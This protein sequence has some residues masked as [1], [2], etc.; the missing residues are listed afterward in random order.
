MRVRLIGLVLLG[1]AVASCGG[2]PSGVFRSDRSSDLLTAPPLTQV[3]GGGLWVAPVTGADA[4]AEAFRKALARSL[5]ERDVPAG[6]D[7]PGPRSLVLAATAG[8][9]THAGGG[10]VDIAWRLT[11]PDGAVLDDFFGRAPLDFRVERPETQAALIAVAD[12]MARLLAPPQAAAPPPPTVVWTPPAET[13]GFA[14]GGPLAR[15]MATALVERGFRPATGVSGAGAVVRAKAVVAPAPGQP[16]AVAVTIRWAVE[17]PDGREMGAA[18]QSNLLPAEFAKDG[19]SAIA[20]MAAA[21]AADSVADLIR[22]A[23][24]APPPSTG[25]GAS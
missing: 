20:P 19:L 7:R 2:A 8:R 17:T 9:P 11:G 25:Q 10:Y 21:A 24:E 14:D 18:D 1:L 23:A 13:E 15:A 6:L 16:D 22:L 3:A 4:E 12:R 5:V